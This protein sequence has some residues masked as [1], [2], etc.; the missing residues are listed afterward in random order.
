MPAVLVA[1]GP[2]RRLCRPSELTR[3][4]P[5]SRQE[6][7]AVGASAVLIYRAL[8]WAGSL[9]LLGPS[10]LPARGLQGVAGLHSGRH[11]SLCPADPGG[12]A[13]TFVFPCILSTGSGWPA[14][15]LQGPLPTCRPLQCCFWTLRSSRPQTL[16]LGSGPGISPWA[17]GTDLEAG[18]PRSEYGR[19]VIFRTGPLWGEG[20]WPS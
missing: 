7:P 4:V 10:C 2:A 15:P 1:W 6:G 17:L 12:K 16:P 20:S 3:S 14:C 13:K 18:T 5:V 19:Q 11:I 9:G 8:L